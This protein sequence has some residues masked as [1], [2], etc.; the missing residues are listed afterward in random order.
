MRSKVGAVARQVPHHGAWNETTAMVVERQI[1]SHQLPSS[2]SRRAA[3]GELARVGTV[4]AL[5]ATGP[6]KATTVSTA[7]MD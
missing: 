7:S 1:S 6:R 5:L 2:S 3:S 4:S